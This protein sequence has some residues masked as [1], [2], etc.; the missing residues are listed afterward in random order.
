MYEPLPLLES[1]L[2]LPS[3]VGIFRNTGL[4]FYPRIRNLS[5]EQVLEPL[6]GRTASF[7][8]MRCVARPS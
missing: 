2:K 8:R 7:P 6:R 5:R 4:L 3:T 1:H